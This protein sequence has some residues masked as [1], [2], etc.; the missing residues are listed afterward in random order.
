MH[1]R[2]APANVR[3]S[4]ERA[5]MVSESSFGESVAL[6]PPK[7]PKNALPEPQKSEAIVLVVELRKTLRIVIIRGGVKIKK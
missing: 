2:G 6:P 3:D 4:P 5:R 7:Q 1:G